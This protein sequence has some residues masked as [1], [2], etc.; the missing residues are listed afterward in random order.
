MRLPSLW[1]FGSSRLSYQPSL[2]TVALLDVLPTLFTEGCGCDADDESNVVSHM[3]DSID[4]RE[5]ALRREKLY[6]LEQ[7]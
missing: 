7:F 5:I 6:D 1:R 3:E 2:N 4:L